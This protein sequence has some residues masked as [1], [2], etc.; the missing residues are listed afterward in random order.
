MTAAA[1][2]LGHRKG[3]IGMTYTSKEIACKCGN[4]VTVDRERVWCKNCAQPVYYHEGAQSKHK[5]N[6]VYVGAMIIC[7]IF[8][9]SYMFMELI[10]KPWLEW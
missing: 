5:W 9:L 1:N 4:I 8:F 2:V 3:S 6:T 7:T 10:A